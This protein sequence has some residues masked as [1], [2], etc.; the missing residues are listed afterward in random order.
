VHIQK[1][2]LDEL[3]FPELLA[4]ISPF[5]FSP[6]TAAKITQLRPVV[7]EDAELSLKK[8]AEFLSSF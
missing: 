8:A 6:K 2:D 1:E 5:A 7:M 3:E 4:E